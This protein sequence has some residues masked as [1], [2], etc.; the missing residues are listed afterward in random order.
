MEQLRERVEEAFA[1]RA[2]LADPEVRQ[3]VHTTIAALDAGKL[4]VAEKVGGEWVVHTW[5]KQAILCG[6]R[7]TTEHP[8][9]RIEKRPALRGKQGMWTLF[10]EGGQVLKRG[11][12]LAQVLKVLE[13]SASRSWAEISPA[14][15]Q[16][17]ST[18]VEKSK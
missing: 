16:A 8:Q 15:P 5:V 18:T 6:F 17:S 2:R 10:G 12:D 9:A 11:H 13:K 14:C 7:R 4:R 3:A 1:D